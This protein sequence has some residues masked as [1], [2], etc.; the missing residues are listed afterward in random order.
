MALTSTLFFGLW[1]V[2][3]VVAPAVISTA[4]HSE[5]QAGDDDKSAAEN[6]LFFVVLA[7][8]AIHGK[9]GIS[10]GACTANTSRTELSSI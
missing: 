1:L 9:D 10:L 4:F 6:G 5:L 8:V 2:V 7:L 3:A